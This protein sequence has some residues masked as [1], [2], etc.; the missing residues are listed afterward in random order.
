M[1]RSFLWVCVGMLA[2][3]CGK[4]E[5]AE[6]EQTSPSRKPEAGITTSDDAAVVMR[7]DAARPAEPTKPD[8]PP[9]APAKPAKDAAAPPNPTPDAAVSRDAQ[10]PPP[11]MDAAPTPPMDA[12]VPVPKT[13]VGTKPLEAWVADPKLCVYVFAENVRAARGMVFAP[14]GDLFLISAG[15]VVV[16]WDA[17]NDGT[18]SMTER[19]TFG[20]APSLNHGI[21]FSRDNKFLYVSSDTTVYRFTYANAQRSAQGAAQVV[22]SGIPPAGHSTRT[23]AFDSQGRLIVSVG[24]ASNVDTAQSDWDLRSQIRRFTI[25]ATLPS[26]GL[27]Y[28][29]GE[30]IASGMRNEAGIFVDAD[31]RIWGV[32]NGRDNLDH[33][34]LGGDIHNDNPGEEINLVD[35][36]GPKF[37][38]YPQCFSEFKLGAGR[39]LGAQWA[40]QSLAANLRRTDAS[41]R[42]A[43]QVRAPV[44]VMPA[45][46]APLGVIRYT[47]SALPMKGD[48]I[49]G[50]HG[51]WNR[52][53]PSGR[54]IARARLQGTTVMG[55]EVLVG[56]KD[57][58]GKLKEGNWNVR[59]VDVRQGPD[60]AV[61]FSD[62]NGG[63]VL[64]I[65]Y[66]N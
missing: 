1:A 63:R 23:L 8:V 57:S 53:P 58:A 47:G 30:V 21:A 52:N 27:A 60:D 38:G 46:W 2:A 44:Y 45:H 9:D 12:A 56:E 29:S 10:T 19:A 14:N 31:D 49:I 51:S 64:K 61:Y 18:S 62:D 16:L 7:P 54:V 20:T 34:E 41:C 6:H 13:C 59:P 50:A 48:L 24:S 25:P 42:D 22:V 39:G 32:E 40:D 15:S 35:G 33:A 65:G 5:P 43:T 26:G 28:T 17:N 55:F 37:Y 11:P 66:A 4:H 36:Q 3:A